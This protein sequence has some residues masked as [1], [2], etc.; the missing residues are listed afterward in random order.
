MRLKVA[1]IGGGISGLASA[2][3]VS[4][5][6]HD[7]TLFEGE[8]YL[9]GLGT[10]FPWRGGHLERFYHC[11]L[12]SDTSLVA[13][14]RELGLGGQLLWKRTRMG[15][16]YRG[17]I[18]PLDG[19]LD[20]LRFGPLSLTERLRLGLL[21]L[22]IR[23]RGLDP[24]LDQVTARD[25]IRA[26]IGE[27]AF[28]I[29][30]RPLLEAK[31]GDHYPGLPAL[32][33]SSR[34]NREKASGPE[35]KGCLVGGYRTLIDAFE[36][37]L[38]ERGATLRLGTR[39]EAIERDGEAL[40]LG[41]A[42]GSGAT[43]DLVVA[44]SPLPQFQRMAAGL[45]LDA[46]FSGLRLDYQGVVSAVLLMDRPLS[47]CYWIPIVDSGATFQGVVEMSNLVPLERSQ[48]LWVTYLMNY[49]H[50]D[51]P[52]FAR[53]DAEI[54][55]LY[56]ADL[57]RLFPGSSAGIRDQYVFRAPYVEP[58]WTLDYQRLA[59]P[60]TVIPGRLYLASTAQVYP[61]VNSWDSCCE[62]ADRM[63]AGLQADLAAGVPQAAGARA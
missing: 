56:R 17:R 1:V 14:I 43:F 26:R 13:L 32:W 30:W 23:R 58:I 2:Y 34:L 54:L 40:R 25:W 53:S 29:L 24:A 48:G 9:G 38:R 4:G 46:R 37:R 36:A 19:P 21:G 28:E 33:L 15:F 57:D 61:R 55:G 10:T 49:T 3:R 47:P 59:P 44:T 41:L 39:I 63:V 31:I 5:L 20:L 45:G 8:S 16:M 6:G 42:G 18:W 22:E 27:R 51:G 60:T 35:V 7:V 11:M 62:V 52:F 12:P 50:R